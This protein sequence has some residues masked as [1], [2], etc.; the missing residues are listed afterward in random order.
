[1]AGGGERGGGVCVKSILFKKQ[2][3]VNQRHF[4]ATDSDQIQG[5]DNEVVGE[6]RERDGLTL[7]VK[8]KKLSKL[9]MVGAIRIQTTVSVSIKPSHG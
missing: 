7:R 8:F 2:G 9:S 4:K 3:W 1:M 5:C 6:K